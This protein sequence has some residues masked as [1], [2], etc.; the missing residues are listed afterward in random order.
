[1][2]TLKAPFCFSAQCAP[3]RYTHFTLRGSGERLTALEIHVPIDHN[4][5][6]KY[7]E[8]ITT[9]RATNG[10]V[11]R[12]ETQKQRCSPLDSLYSLITIQRR[13]RR[14]AGP[15]SITIHSTWS[16]LRPAQRGAVSDPRE[17]RR[18]RH[19]AREHPRSSARARSIEREGESMSSK[20]THAAHRLGKR[21][22]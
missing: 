1:M 14:T 19:R 6:K 10:C 8:A 18:H 3:F 9:V 7:H 13:D 2:G 15:C 22:H 16:R 12:R 5:R 17:E 21:V 11:P 4:Q 20:R